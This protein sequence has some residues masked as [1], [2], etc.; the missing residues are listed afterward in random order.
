MSLR[1]LRVQLARLKARAET[2]DAPPWQEVVAAMGRG[3]GRARA[4]LTSAPVDQKE[5]QRDSELLERW[6]RSQGISHTVIAQRAGE[7]RARL[8]MPRE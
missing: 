5:A 7:A 4:R 2:K 8:L 3:A 6:R 1:D